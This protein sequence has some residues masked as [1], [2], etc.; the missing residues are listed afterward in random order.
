LYRL[1]HRRPSRRGWEDVGKRYLVD[2]E[3]V[4]VGGDGIG[5]I[6]VSPVQPYGDSPAHDHRIPAP[7]ARSGRVGVDE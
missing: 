4:A 2:G 3:W 5:R 1:E 7:A 6:L